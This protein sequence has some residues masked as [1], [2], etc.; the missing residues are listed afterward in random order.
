MDYSLYD[1]ETL[2]MVEALVRRDAD[3]CEERERTECEP[4]W[5]E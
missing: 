4:A 5:E 1:P 2:A 3:A